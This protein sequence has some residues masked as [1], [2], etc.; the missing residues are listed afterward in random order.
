VIAVNE[1]QSHVS[2]ANKLKIRKSAVEFE[3]DNIFPLP[4]FGTSI[5]SNMQVDHGDIVIRL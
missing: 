3:L 2:N 5:I 1:F 4:V